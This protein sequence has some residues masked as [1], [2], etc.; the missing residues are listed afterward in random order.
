LHLANPMHTHTHPYICQQGHSSQSLSR[1]TF[2]KYKIQA[3]K[4]L[5]AW[6]GR[7]MRTTRGENAVSANG[8]LEKGHPQQHC[9]V[10]GPPL[11]SPV[12]SSPHLFTWYHNMVPAS[13]SDRQL[14]RTWTWTR[15][16]IGGFHVHRLT[17]PWCQRQWGASVA[18]QR[19]SLNVLGW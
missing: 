13:N 4:N 17:R 8:A 10:K 16:E 7:W 3:G 11:G 5:P 12:P 15:R 2:P 6:G 1:G 19:T 14:G 9:E 18:S